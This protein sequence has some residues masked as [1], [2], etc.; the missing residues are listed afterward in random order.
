MIYSCRYPNGIVKQYTR[1]PE[2]PAGGRWICEKKDNNMGFYYLK[3]PSVEITFRTEAG[4]WKYM[5]DDL[6]STNNLPPIPQREGE[7]GSWVFPYD[8]SKPLIIEPKYRVNNYV[9]K[10]I[11]CS[12]E[13][14]IPF[15]KNNP[16]KKIPKVTPQPGLVGIW[17]PFTVKYED[18]TVRAI[19]EPRHIKF[20]YDGKEEIQPYSSCKFPE[21]KEKPGFYR[22]WKMPNCIS[23]N[24]HI[25]LRPIEEPIR[26]KIIFKNTRLDIQFTVVFDITMD[27]IQEPRLSSPAPDIVASWSS[28]DLSC[29][30]N[31]ESVPVYRP[32][33]IHL[34][35]PDGT[36]LSIDY[37]NDLE[38]PDIDGYVWPPYKLESHDLDLYPIPKVCFALFYV[39]SN[40][41]YI[42]P[43]TH[44]D[45]RYVEEMLN[46]CTVPRYKKMFGIWEL[47]K[48][49]DELEYYIAK[50]F[51][52][53]KPKK[54][55][56]P[57]IDWNIAGLADYLYNNG[58]VINIQDQQVDLFYTRFSEISGLT[59]DNLETQRSLLF[60]QWLKREN[61]EYYDN[62]SSY[63]VVDTSKE[64][65]KV[66][67]NGK[68]TS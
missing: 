35:H 43:Y 56:R 33:K 52:D 9:A 1:L 58:S 23:R 38:L 4:T 48:S 55:Y 30:K 53:I 10:F 7:T 12:G 40:L 50:Y 22:Q 15:N 25:E 41:T 5:S 32:V 36:V 24:E 19:Y 66:Y 6:P 64:G 27:H 67:L 13:L 54:I 34:H 31:Q 3:I 37:H 47:K 65:L 8:L 42:V 46:E 20:I 28:Y 17:E 57:S 21:L 44:K 18:F 60:L 63:R 29:P 68:F 51:D 2:T 16:L 11:D 39:N 49:N 26:Y 62:V 61:V 59:R 14:R 45:R